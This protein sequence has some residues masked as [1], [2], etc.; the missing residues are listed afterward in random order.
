MQQ[1]QEVGGEN[2]CE[3][4]WE[5]FVWRCLW[6]YL[7][8]SD[9][10]D[11]CL[12]SVILTLLTVLW[13]TNRTT[14]CW[15]ESSSVTILQTEAVKGHI[16]HLSSYK[17]SQTRLPDRHLLVSG[18]SRTGTLLASLIRSGGD[19]VL[20]IFSTILGHTSDESSLNNIGFSFAKLPGV[21]YK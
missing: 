1:Q 13:L 18:V 16:S 2:I 10:S 5:I 7:V 12:H 15:S 20:S 8:L 14:S 9:M 17:I 11:L 4:I 21:R 6:Y 19:D 3:N